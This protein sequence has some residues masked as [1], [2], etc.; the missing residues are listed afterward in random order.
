MFTQNDP[1]FDAIWATIR[2]G[3][4]YQMQHLVSQAV[5][6]LERYFTDD[7]A[8]WGKGTL[9]ASHAPLKAAH[10]IG[11]VNLA[12]FVDEPSFLSTALLLY[13]SLDEDIVNGF[14]REYG[15]REMLSQMISRAAS[16]RVRA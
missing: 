5:Y 8:F 1:A 14:V 4:Q 11:I 12:R 9:F 3:H 7:L 15:S 6:Y 16:A 10:A 2:I 13:C